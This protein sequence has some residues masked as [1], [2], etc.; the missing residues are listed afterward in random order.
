MLKDDV[1]SSFDNFWQVSQSTGD[2]FHTKLLVVV[3]SKEV[4]SWSA[5]KWEWT[6]DLVFAI[7]L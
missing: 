3:T 2:G 1:H 6:G 4:L 7:Y 5:E